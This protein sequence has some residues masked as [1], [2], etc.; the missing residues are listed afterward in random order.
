MNFVSSWKMANI[1]FLCT[2]TQALSVMRP[3]A[4]S[5]HKIFFISNE[6]GNYADASRYTT[7]TYYTE[8]KVEDEEFLKLTVEVVRI[9]KIDTLI[10]S[11]DAAAELVSKNL[12]MIGKLV[13][14]Q[15][16]N[17]D[18]FLKGY[19]KN[20]LMKLCR[21]NGYPHPETID[22]SSV[23]IND[24]RV[25]DSFP[26]P[27]LLKPNCTTG[28]RGMTMIENYNAL[29]ELYPQIK[30]QFGDC[31][32][33]RFIREGGR[34]VKVQLYIDEKGN[35]VNSS[36]L[37]K[38][39]W[40]PVKGGSSC[41]AVSIE[42]KNIVEICYN[43]LKDINW[44]GFA[45]FDSIEDEKT[46]ELLIMEI[47]PRIPACIGAAVHAGINWGQIIIDGNMGNK[48]A[49]YTYKTGV[50]LRH[51]GFDVLWF[52]KSPHRFKTK[53]S[54]FR[55]FGSK[56]VYQDLSLTD[57]MPFFVGTY[58]NIKKLFNSEFKKAKKG[59]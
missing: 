39:R 55:F 41:C 9:E 27:G 25:F 18:T 14:I 22:M 42:D 44:V 31:H 5:G 6:H 10:P 40:Y 43:V 3:L 4:K 2:G 59:V 50:V 17:Y 49:T 56:I 23:D 26:F 54:W 13:K 35:L 38:V 28:G 45:D 46:H 57:P 58:H 24:S 20:Q 48:Q 8:A 19:D 37:D 36:V 15:A 1:L 16:P 51:L 12:N 53:P 11:G 29:K 33:Q 30:S 7:R 34:Q 52:L 32:L 21:K 47:N